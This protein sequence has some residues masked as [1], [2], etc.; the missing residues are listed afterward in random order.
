VVFLPADT[1]GAARLRELASARA[2]H[3]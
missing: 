1:E 2:G 3:G